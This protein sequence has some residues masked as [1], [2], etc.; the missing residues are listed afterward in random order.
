MFHKYASQI[1]G[2]MQSILSYSSRV[3]EFTHHVQG[4]CTLYGDY[5]ENDFT[6]LVSLR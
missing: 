5:L 2:N 1:G 4:Q 6:L 3:R